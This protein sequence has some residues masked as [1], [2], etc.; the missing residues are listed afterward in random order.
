MKI[1]QCVDTFQLGGPTTETVDIPD[2]DPLFL[3]LAKEKKLSKPERK[4][5][6]P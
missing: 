3:D 1:T 2:D 5:K 4:A 6:T